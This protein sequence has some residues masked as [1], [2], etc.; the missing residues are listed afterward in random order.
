MIIFKTVRWKNFLSTGNAFNEM[1]LDTNEATLVI[2]DNGAG[3]TTF[4][5]ALFYG[6]YGKPYRKINKPLLLN[7]IN[8]KGLVVEVEFSIGGKEY[9]IRRGMKPTLFE[10]Y[11]D[12]LMEDQ[13]AAARDYQETIDK[14][15]L[16]ISQRTMS[17]IVVLG[18]SSY[19]PF[20]RLAAGHRREVV[21]DLLDLQVFS[22]MNA[23][24]KNK[25]DANK[26]AIERSTTDIN[27][28]RDKIE[29]VKKHLASLQADNQLRAKVNL[30][31]IAE[32]ESTIASAQHKTNEYTAT[33]VDLNA[34]I[35][36]LTKFSGRRSKLRELN[37]CLSSNKT[38]L[39]NAVEFYQ[40]NENCPSCKQNID[41]D[42]RQLTIEDK[43][44]K[45]SL[46]T[47]GL[48]K[49]K[50]ELARALIEIDNITKIQTKISQLQGSITENQWAVNSLS[51]INEALATEANELMSTKHVE[52]EEQS[53]LSEFME[54]LGDKRALLENDQKRR[55]IIN[56][57]QKIL[58]DTGI[59]TRII[60]QYIPVINK[61]VNKYMAA[62]DF[63][64]QFELDE[65]FNET[66]KSR[67]RDTFSYESFSDGEKMRIDLS[68]LFTWRA[69][70]KIRNSASTNLL[71]MDEVFD[72]SLDAAGV[73]DIIKIVKEFTK[74]NS[75]FI[76]SHKNDRLIDQFKR[77]VK[78]EKYKS[79]STIAA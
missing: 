79:F 59:K 48:D 42:F 28:L 66:I 4:L 47:Q 39:T 16:K 14:D 72:S 17:Q 56:T 78:F 75:V 37:A 53:D 6:L 15:I 3:K 57:A 29:L 73:D 31:K 27:V 30:E 20:M 62:M 77:T 38:Q 67:H 36:D 22:V 71:I 65:E 32:N 45:L 70:A 68:L 33:I 24:L 43:K 51:N 69:I 54:Q 13:D 12:G 25:V 41:E 50:T 11:I 2:G 10:V 23:L 21:E 61:L 7:S 46:V 74:D 52:A 19:I 34:Q 9:T 58:K 35:T 5:D 18:A 44:D 1:R 64:V 49:I 55:S 60:K 76:M 63:F 8:K 26:I 40:T